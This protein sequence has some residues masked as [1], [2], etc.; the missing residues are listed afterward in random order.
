MR[1]QMSDRQWAAPSRAAR[2]RGRRPFLHEPRPPVARRLL[3]G[4]AARPPMDQR[5]P[6]DGYTRIVT[7]RRNPIP[8]GWFITIEGPEGGGKT[9]QAA[10]LRARLDAAGVPTVLTREP[11]GTP[12]G[13]RIR[14]IL[15]EATLPIAPLADAFLFNAARAQL[16]A[17]VIRPAISR[18]ETVICVRF[19]DSTLAYQGFGAGVP[20]RDLRALERVAT[21]GLSPDLTLLLDLPAEVGLAR[22]RGQ[23]ETRFEGAFDLAFHHR[24]R[25]GFLEL[26]AAEPARFALIDAS[27]PEDRVFE[28]MAA[29]VDE[30]LP[31]LPGPTGS[32]GRDHVVRNGTPSEPEVDS[33]RSIR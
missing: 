10:L 5:Q 14:S 29:A 20:L 25:A 1:A 6:A 17:D 23:E 16:V 9:Y 3:H 32:T 21:V 15:L 31:N 22:K 7:T 24:V 30:R 2:G 19:A 11:G 33:V 8:R 4:F 28:A 27:V 26:L 18:G 12:L 13:E